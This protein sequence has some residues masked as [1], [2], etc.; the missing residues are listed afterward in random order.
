[1]NAS[2]Q[3]PSDTDSRTNRRISAS[4]LTSLLTLTLLFSTTASAS[5]QLLL[6]RGDT[7]EHVGEYKG[8]VDLTIDPGFEGAK[9]SVAVDGQKIAD[10]VLSP[11]HLVVDFGPVATQHK[12][13][14]TATGAKGKR[15]KWTETINQGNLPLSINIRQI[16]ARVFEV[17]A[18]S[19]KED[20]I[21][22]VQLWD[23]GR[24]VAETKERPYRFTVADSL[25]A[26]GF[27][28]VTAKT[29]G[30][31]ETADFWSPA[32]NIVAEELQVR[33]VPIFVSVVD[34]DGQTRDDIQRSQFRIIDNESEAK[35][36]DTY[37]EV[38]SVSDV[39]HLTYP[40]PAK[41]REIMDRSRRSR[42]GH[43]RSPPGPRTPASGLRPSADG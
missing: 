1:M 24:L 3:H 7:S 15:V 29:N 6:K 27:V 34:R 23:D 41:F 43:G 2:T 14:V 17:D 4:L 33:T 31:E 25:I 11:Y 12:I 40:D 35:I 42:S 13:T 9:V 39:F 32:G 28:Q 22:V 36:I 16:E 10:S 20:P 21:A 37:K 18:T 8:V 38:G 30:G 5:T 26:S 19:P